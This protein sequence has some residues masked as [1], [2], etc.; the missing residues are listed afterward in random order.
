MTEQSLIVSPPPT[1][2]LLGSFSSSSF[3]FSGLRVSP[4]CI[5][6]IGFEVVLV[7]DPEAE[8]GPGRIGADSAYKIDWIDFWGEGVNIR[9]RG[10]KSMYLFLLDGSSEWY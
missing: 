8:M 5:G 9:R 10:K 4:G 3:T 1:P 2:F 7:L 6:C